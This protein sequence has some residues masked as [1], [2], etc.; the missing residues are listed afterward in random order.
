MVI[1]VVDIKC[2]N[3]KVFMECGSSCPPATCENHEPSDLCTKECVPGCFCKEGDVLNEDGVC[4]KLTDCP[5]TLLNSIF[6]YVFVCNMLVIKSID[7]LIE[8]EL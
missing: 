1:H 8:Y 3:N 4:V 5:G 7:C 6:V 2:A